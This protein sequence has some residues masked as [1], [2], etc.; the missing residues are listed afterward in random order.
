MASSLFFMRVA[1]YN[2]AKFD[3]NE[4]FE[5]IVNR[6]PHIE[7]WIDSIRPLLCDTTIISATGQRLF[8]RYAPA[9]NPSDNTAIIIHGYKSNSVAMMHIGYMFH[10]D[11]GYNILLPDLQSHGYSE[12]E[13]IQMG[14][15]DKDDVR[16]WIDVAISEFGNNTHIVI[17]GIS[18]G[19]ATTMM[20]SGENLPSNVK[21][22]VEDCGYTS[23]WDEFRG[24]LR[25]QYHLPAFPLL[26]ITSGL[27]DLTLGWSFGEA[28]SLEQVKKCQLPMMFIHG[29]NDT[30][31][32]TEMV[33]PL[34]EAKAEPK[35]IYISKGSA[36]AVSY[37]DNP[38]AYTQR[39]GAFVAKYCR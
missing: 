32:P 37:Q 31:V 30:Y 38:A 36:H 9:N 35:E 14:W 10:H 23:V 28:S 2:D 20:V 19:G 22:F 7:Q 18:M 29:G 21:C 26:N 39:V 12:G 5:K 4:Q 17:T 3:E 13:Y 15:K 6:Y 33:Y 27:C 16:Q 34:Y 8:A 11:F 25:N 1:L 24:E